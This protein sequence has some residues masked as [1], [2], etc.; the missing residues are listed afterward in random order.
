MYLNVQPKIKEMTF[1]IELSRKGDNV[2][3][4][5]EYNQHRMVLSDLMTEG[6]VLNYAESEKRDKFWIIMDSFS[7]NEAIDVISDLPIV[8][9]L[10]VSVIP[11]FTNVSHFSKGAV[12]SLN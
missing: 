7:E 2:F 5:L 1:M 10:K 6:I 12:Y 11:L 8:K 3:S 9:S 4:S